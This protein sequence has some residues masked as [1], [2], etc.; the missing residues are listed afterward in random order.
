M[1]LPTFHL[2]GRRPDL[3]VANRDVL[4]VFLVNRAAENGPAGPQ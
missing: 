4:M 3:S 2:G 1:K